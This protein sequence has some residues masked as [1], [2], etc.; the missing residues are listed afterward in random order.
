MSPSP[1]LAHSSY[2]GFLSDPQTS[3]TQSPMGML[4]RKKW[5]DKRLENLQDMVA[6]GGCSQERPEGARVGGWGV[7]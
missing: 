3:L 4:K 1:P 2:S 6:N 5:K 7:G